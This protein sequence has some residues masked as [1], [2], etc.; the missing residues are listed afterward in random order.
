MNQG[1]WRLLVQGCLQPIW[2]SL[3]TSVQGGC[4][5]S[6]LILQ[7]SQNTSLC[8]PS[9]A[10]TPVETEKASNLSLRLSPSLSL[11]QYKYTDTKTQMSCASPFVSSPSSLPPLHPDPVHPGGIC[12]SLCSF[13]PP[14]HCRYFLSNLFCWWM[15]ITIIKQKQKKNWQPIKRPNF[16]KCISFQ[17]KLYTKFNTWKSTRRRDGPGI[18]AL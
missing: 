15:R 4:V 10:P 14:L 18:A 8:R 12:P 2:W 17:F 5:W 6:E 7:C 9:S 13:S 11:S 3:L 16:M 1:C